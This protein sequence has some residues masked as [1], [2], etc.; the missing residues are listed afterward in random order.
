MLWDADTGQAQS[1]ARPGTNRVH[2]LV[3]SLDSRHLAAADDAKTLAQMG[4][5]DDTRRTVHV[6]DLG[7][8][9]QTHIFSTD[10]GEFPVS[11]TFSADAKAFVAGFSK[12]PVKLWPLDGPAEATAFLGHSGWV[13]GLAVLTNGPTLISAGP[14]IRFW[15][16]RTRHENAHKLSPTAG[17]YRCLSL[18]PDGRR[19]AAGASDGRITIW[20]ATSHEEVATLEGHKEAVMQLAFTPDGDYLVS[21]SKD[22]LRVWRAPSWAEI[23]AAENERK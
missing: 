6:W 2:L 16:V 19:L 17:G 10:D 13:W 20:D 9:K 7:T 11:L 21:V 22:Q 15:D 1:F 14:D 23:E 8:R 18:S 12:G 4:V 3:F 5:A